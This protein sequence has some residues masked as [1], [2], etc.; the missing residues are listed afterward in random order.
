MSI[1]QAILYDKVENYLLRNGTNYSFDLKLVLA[2]L[3]KIVFHDYIKDCVIRGGRTNW[4]KLPRNKSLFFTPP[5]FGLPIGNLTSQLFSN[6]YLN[7]FDHFIKRTLKFKYYGRYV[8]DLIIIDG[9]KE[10][11]KKTII[12]IAEYLSTN[13]NLKIH[14]RKIYLQPYV[15]GVNFLGGIVKPTEFMSATGLKPVFIV[16]QLRLIMF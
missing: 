12:L 6:V 16:P 10:K 11:L 5:G 4:Q 2:L 14:P 13:L 15:K 3:K 1:N 9:N 7:D 8:D